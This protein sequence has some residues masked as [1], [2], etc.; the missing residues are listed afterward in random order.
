MSFKTLFNTLMLFKQFRRPRYLDNFAHYSKFKEDAAAGALPNLSFIDPRYA[1]LGQRWP[2]NDFHPGNS[3]DNIVSEGEILI[4][5]IY[6]TL[7]A[8]PVWNNTAFV[9]TFDEAGGFYDHIPSPS[10]VPN[11]DGKVCPNTDFTQMGVRIPTV[12]VSPRVPKGTVVHTP[13]EGPFADSQYE[14]SSIP[15]TLRK[16]FE[17]DEEPLTARAAWAGTFENLFT[18]RV[19]TDCPETMPDVPMVSTQAFLDP[20]A[21]PI[22]DLQQ[23][24]VALASGLTAG[25]DDEIMTG[26][27]WTEGDAALFMREQVC[28]FFGRCMYEGE[29]SYDGAYCAGP[30]AVV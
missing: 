6:E 28:A 10:G 15:A 22:T 9:I 14:A 13:T 24:F 21:T 23:D 25:S 3:R 5:D 2:Q 16:L 30:S 4:K 12:V 1:T 7:R 20:F 11:P 29:D 18:T 26:E 8:S 19:R 17:I 27:G